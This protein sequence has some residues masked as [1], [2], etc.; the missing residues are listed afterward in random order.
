MFECRKI[1]GHTWPRCTREKDQSG[2]WYAS[3]VITG[4]SSACSAEEILEA[5]GAHIQCA[6]G[7]REEAPLLLG[8]AKQIPVKIHSL[9]F[10]W[11]DWELLPRIWKVLVQHCNDLISVSTRAREL[12]RKARTPL[13]VTAEEPRHLF[14][15]RQGGAGPALQSLPWSSQSP[16]LHR[17]D[18]KDYVNCYFCYV[19][20]NPVPTM[21]LY[22][23][24][25]HAR[26]QCTQWP[27]NFHP[28]QKWLR[29]QRPN[30]LLKWDP[31]VKK[32]E[33]CWYLILG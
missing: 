17:Q 6:S 9:R 1:C 3:P 2:S 5:R 28:P 26:L 20:L 8:P 25:L 18:A 7:A 14:S 4:I 31:P 19:Q 32:R 22:I 21:T 12:K 27:P 24:L 11:Q 30:K 23:P 10:S 33:G 29:H 13:V 16:S 15:P